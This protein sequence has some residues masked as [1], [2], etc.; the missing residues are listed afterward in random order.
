MIHRYFGLLKVYM[1]KYTLFAYKYSSEGFQAT[2]HWTMI[3]LHYKNIL[4]T[5][6]K[7]IR[8]KERTEQSH[9]ISKKK[10]TNFYHK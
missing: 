10:K 1:K 8:G 3:T 9:G 6:S 4:S 2:T 7:K 5:P